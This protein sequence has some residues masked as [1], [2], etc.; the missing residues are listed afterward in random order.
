MHARAIP[1]ALQDRITDYYHVSRRPAPRR[2]SD[3]RPGSITRI[4]DSDAP[5][6]SPGRDPSAVFMASNS[7]ARLGYVTRMCGACVTRMRG[8]DA[9]LGCVTQLEYATHARA[10]GMAGAAPDGLRPVRC[11]TRMCDSDV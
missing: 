5:G 2:D 1:R 8:S 10:G 11:V 3:A 7:D 9:R 4:R 6:P